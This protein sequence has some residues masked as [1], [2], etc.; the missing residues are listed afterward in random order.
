[1]LATHPLT[2]HRA[3]NSAMKITYGIAVQLLFKARSVVYN[4]Y[5][6]SNNAKLLN[7]DHY[8]KTFF[9]FVDIIVIKVTKFWPKISNERKKQF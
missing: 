6:I 9:S 1:M 5:N 7:N 8:I 2:M 3:M 4:L